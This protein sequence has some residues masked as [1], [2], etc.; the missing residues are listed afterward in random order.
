MLAKEVEMMMRTIWS[1]ISFLKQTCLFLRT[2][3]SV[4]W[5]VLDD[6]FTP[7]LDQMGQ[8][9][10]GRYYVLTQSVPS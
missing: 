4:G 10:G 5:E 9:P 3:T 6:L 7:L 8:A 1:S 2:Q